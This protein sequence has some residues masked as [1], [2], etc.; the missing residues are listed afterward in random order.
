MAESRWPTRLGSAHEPLQVN[1]D[2]NAAD[3][4]LGELDLPETLSPARLE[5]RR[6]LFS[7]LADAAID[8]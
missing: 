3:F 6:A 1:R 4:H 7:R 2:P 8:G 5:D